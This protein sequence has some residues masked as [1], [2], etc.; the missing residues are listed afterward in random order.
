[1]TTSFHVASSE[2]SR[3]VWVSHPV[4]WLLAGIGARWS[5]AGS[6]LEL[7]ATGR[8]GAELAPIMYGR[9]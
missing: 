4:V 1:M 3:I 7:H 9:S 2:A 6:M 8:D 5:R